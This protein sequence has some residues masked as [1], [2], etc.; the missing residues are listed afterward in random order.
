MDTATRRRLIWLFFALALVTLRPG[1]A[2]A[3]AGNGLKYS[4]DWCYIGGSPAGAIFGS[5]AAALQCWIDNYLAELHTDP[6]QEMCRAD[7]SDPLEPA[8]TDPTTWNAT[9]TFIADSTPCA[10][11]PAGSPGYPWTFNPPLHRVACTGGDFDPGGPCAPVSEECDMSLCPVGTRLTD[12]GGAGS[13]CD[14]DCNCVLNL[15]S[16]T[17]GINSYH[18]SGESCAGGEDEAPDDL[19][20]DEMC[21]AVGDGQYCVSPAGDGQCGYLNDSYVCLNRIAP[22]ECALDGSGG[23]LCGPAAVTT[24]PVPDSGTAGVPAAPDDTVSQTTPAGAGGGSSSSSGGGGSVTYNYYGPGTVTGSDRD[25]G[26]TG[27]GPS[28]GV[29]SSPSEGPTEG[30]VGEAVGGAPTLPSTEH[31]FSSLDDDLVSVGGSCPEPPSVTVF[32]SEIE[33]SAVTWFCELASML[34][35]LVLAS[36][37]LTAILIVGRGL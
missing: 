25:P 10:A 2:A 3:D 37:W 22:D 27:A 4:N 16:S 34:S 30:D 32:G 31:D 35:G 21:T 7:S 9:A 6:S 8:G 15:T 13:V 19:T 18:N 29:G 12:T 36:A 20:G 11:A 33:L 28:S 24:P 5:A 14:T 1:T 23:R 26:T 17:N